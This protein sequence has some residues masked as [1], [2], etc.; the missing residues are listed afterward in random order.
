MKEL[1]KLPDLVLRIAQS[2]E[3]HHLPTY[4]TSLAQAF[5][6]FYRDCPVLDAEPDVRAARLTLVRATQVVLANTLGL[7]GIRAPEKM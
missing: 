5:S 1:V 2:Y 7:M 4:A 3:V 6:V